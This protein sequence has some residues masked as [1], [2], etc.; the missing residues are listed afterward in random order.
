[1]CCDLLEC[2]AVST[3]ERLLTLQL[4]VLRVEAMQEDSEDRCNTLLRNVD[5]YQSTGRNIPEVLYVQLK[6]VWRRA[7][8]FSGQGC[9]RRRA[10]I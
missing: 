2:C 3:G 8:M 9:T 7:C 1:M 6:A 5:I 10:V 4:G